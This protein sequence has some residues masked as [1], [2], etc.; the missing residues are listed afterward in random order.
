LHSLSAES[1]LVAEKLFDIPK[2]WELKEICG[3]DFWNI[4]YV[5]EACIMPDGK[6]G[7]ALQ[8]GEFP[9][10]RKFLNKHPFMF[11]AGYS[12]APT[13]LAAGKFRLC[14]WE[15]EV[16]SPGSNNNIASQ[17]KV[18]AG[19]ENGEVKKT[20]AVTDG[21]LNTA[22]YSDPP[23]NLFLSGSFV[24]DFGSKKNRTPHPPP[25]SKG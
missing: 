19:C 9:E 2:M 24:L 20:A 1:D 21:N 5:G 10:K 18:S 13:S 8:K 16:Y 6:P 3:R 12:V 11:D 7:F 17:A 22:A 14:L 23:E 25:W 4:R 15:I